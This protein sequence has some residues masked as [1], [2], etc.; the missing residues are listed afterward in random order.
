MAVA[1]KVLMVRNVGLQVA[2]K[3][4]CGKRYRCNYE[5]VMNC[6]YGES[7]CVLHVSVRTQDILSRYMAAGK[8][9]PH[10]KPTAR[11]GKLEWRGILTCLFAV[12]S[13][14]TRSECAC[15]ERDEMQVH[16]EEI[17]MVAR[18][19]GGAMAASGN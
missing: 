9:L 10:W 7:V 12:C 18:V 6:C 17:L 1:A 15:E 13:M 5:I 4:R 2:I 16:E 3:V 11:Q 8:R 14:K 19:R